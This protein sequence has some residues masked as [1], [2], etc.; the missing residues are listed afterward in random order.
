MAKTIA[1]IGT[2]L[3]GAMQRALLSVADDNVCSA[4]E[5]SSSEL[6]GERRSHKRKAVSKVNRN[7]KRSKNEDSLKSMDVNKFLDKIHK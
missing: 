3:A 6:S 5:T 7:L 1:S 2:T 4:A